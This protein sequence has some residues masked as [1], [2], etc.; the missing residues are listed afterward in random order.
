MAYEGPYCLPGRLGVARRWKGVQ[1]LPEHI[2]LGSR[3][4]SCK[5]VEKKGV[6]AARR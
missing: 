2:V 5:S 6:G 4:S 3:F 1:A